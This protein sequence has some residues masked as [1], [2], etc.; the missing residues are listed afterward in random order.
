[1]NLWGYFSGSAYSTFNDGP[2]SFYTVYSDA[3]QKVAEM[4]PDGDWPVFGTARSPWDDVKDFYDVFMGFS[5]TLSFA[6]FDKYKE[7]SDMPRH[8]RR[9]IK[10][11]NETLRRLARQQYGDMVRQLATFCRKRDPRVHF[12]IHKEKREKLEREQRLKD[13]KE[14]KRLASLEARRKWREGGDDDDQAFD[15]YEVRTGTLLGD[16][17]D[18]G[19]RKK[20]KKKKGKGKKTFFDDD[21]DDDDEKGDDDETT[22][23]DAAA[24][25]DDDDEVRTA[26]TAEVDEHGRDDDD[27]DE[28]LTAVVEEEPEEDD[29]AVFSCI[30]CKKTFKSGK[31]LENHLQ[32]KAHKKKAASSGSSGSTGKKS[33]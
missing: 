12:Q 3:F 26:R 7:T 17:D 23:P 6:N 13:M 31:Q 15:A 30:V 1:M 5:T 25:D 22:D 11:E 32:S 27:D 18:G 14:S 10:T 24:A 21:D 33:R 29:D 19:K 20:K 16:M 2:R 28:R 8:V 9:A 4:E